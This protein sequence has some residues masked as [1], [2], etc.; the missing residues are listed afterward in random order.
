VIA[1]T[2]LRYRPTTATDGPALFRLFQQL[3]TDEIATLAVDAATRAALAS[4]QYVEQRV[5]TAAEFPD[6]VDVAIENA[7]GLCG[8]MVTVMRGGGIQLLQLG[9]LV[10]HRGQGI[11]TLAM[12]RLATI[13]EGHGCPIWLRADA[14][15]SDCRGFLERVGFT[16]S[17]RGGRLLVERA[18]AA[19]DRFVA[20]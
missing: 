18:T 13:A 1:A 3:H 20:A 11:G 16:V 5:R 6:A 2:E 4:M 7:A 8:R 9:V 17:G 12:R 19:A 14:T 15:S 10:E